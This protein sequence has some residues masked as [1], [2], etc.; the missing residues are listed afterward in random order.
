MADKIKSKPP[1]K[2]SPHD[3]SDLSSKNPVSITAKV[4]TK[5]RLC[6]M[7]GVIN[8]KTQSTKMEIK[9]APPPVGF[10]TAASGFTVNSRP[11]S[12]GNLE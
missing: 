3:F 6:V 1:F 7:V 11:L 8:K 4:I 10:P 5:T 9:T 12:F 2:Y